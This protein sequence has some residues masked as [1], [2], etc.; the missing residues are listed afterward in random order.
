MSVAPTT[1]SSFYD[2]QDIVYSRAPGTR[3]YYQFNHWTERPQRAIHAQLASRLSTDAAKGGLVLD[4]RVDE[5]YHDALDSPGTAA[6]HDSPR[7]S[8]IRRARAV[9]ARRTFNRSAPAASYDASGAVRGFD[10]AL[11]SLL[12]DIVTWVGQQA[13]ATR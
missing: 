2:T 13:P 3:A 1:S 5:I 6:H 4:T 9:L 8:S 12:D 7:S 10:E 11:G